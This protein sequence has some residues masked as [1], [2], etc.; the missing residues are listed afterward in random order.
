MPCK[1]LLI[2]PKS[3]CIGFFSFIRMKNKYFW[4]KCLRILCFYWEV[5]TSIKLLNCTS[6]KF[7][8]KIYFEVQRTTYFSIETSI[9]ICFS[10]S[11]IVGVEW[12]LFS[13]SS[14]LDRRKRNK[15]PNFSKQTKN[16][17]IFFV[18]RVGPLS[19]PYPAISSRI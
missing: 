4:R 15:F 13:F 3:F 18:E 19:W 1:S 2:R 9:T 11:F 14:T 5:T 17:A 8:N 16:Q 10:G 7:V 6:T 12:I